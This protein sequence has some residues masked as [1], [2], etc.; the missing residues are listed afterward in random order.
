MAVAD[1]MCEPP[2]RDTVDRRAFPAAL[3]GTRLQPVAGG[4]RTRVLSLPS[5]STRWSDGGNVNGLRRCRRVHGRREPSRFIRCHL[6]R[7]GRHRARLAAG[8]S[9]SVVNE[10]FSSLYAL[11]KAGLGCA[12]REFRDRRDVGL[13]KTAAAQTEGLSTSGGLSDVRRISIRT[14]IRFERASRSGS[15]YTTLQGQPPD[16]RKNGGC[17]SRRDVMPATPIVA[18]TIAEFPTRRFLRKESLLLRNTQRELL[19]FMRHQRRSGGR[20]AG[21]LMVVSRNA[22]TQLSALLWR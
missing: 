3:C 10:R 7:S 22:T 6:A 13:V 9:R 1:G 15:H 11:G 19:R 17:G 16:P 4:G 2:R 8:G 18:Q 14:C 12:T 5:S 20:L 21:G